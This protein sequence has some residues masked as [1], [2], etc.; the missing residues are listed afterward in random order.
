VLANNVDSRQFLPE[1]VTLPQLFKNNGWFTAREGKMFHMNVP[2]EVRS[3]KYQDGP[4]WNHSAS[5]PGLEAKTPGEGRR[6]NPPGVGF[7]MQWIAAAS[8]T[9]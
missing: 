8:A 6:L 5:P 1:V 7:G 3:Q 4:S 9:G 2:G